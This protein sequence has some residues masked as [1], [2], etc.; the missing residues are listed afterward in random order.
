MVNRKFAAVLFGVWM[1]A[2]SAPSVAQEILPITGSDVYYCRYE[3]DGSTSLLKLASSPATYVTASVGKELAQLKR[4][5]QSIGGQLAKQ[6]ALLKSIPNRLQLEGRRNKI[7]NKITALVN[8]SGALKAVEG[9]IRRCRDRQLVQSQSMTI[10]ILKVT[11]TS[12]GQSYITA[13]ASRPGPLRI[14]KNVVIGAG[15][16]CLTL[17]GTGEIPFNFPSGTE[18][19]VRLFDSI[20]PKAGTVRCEPPVPANHIG[21]RILTAF[22]PPDPQGTINQFTSRIGDLSIT[23]RPFASGVPCRGLP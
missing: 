20:C 12:S 21:W 16:W 10:T 4:K 17:N 2:V 14:S 8:E 18:T 1:L 5:R 7:K 15:E 11:N 23:A 3:V 19:Q 13:Y 22:N 9:S 6:R